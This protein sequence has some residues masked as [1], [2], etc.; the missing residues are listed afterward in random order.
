MNVEKFSDDL[1]IGV[2]GQSN[3]EIART[4]RNA[5]RCSVAKCCAGGK[6]TEK[7]RGLHRLPTLIKLR[8]PAH[9]SSSEPQG[10]K[11]MGREGNNPEHQ[12]RSLNMVKLH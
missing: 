9:S 6:A 10:A 12:L 1:W 2:K 3:S 4:P 11:V 5:F 7:A 8:M